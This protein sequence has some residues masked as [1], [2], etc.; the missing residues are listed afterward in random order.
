MLSLMQN[1]S[2]Y[3][4]YDKYNSKL[5]FWNNT[6]GHWPIN[7]QYLYYQTVYNPYKYNKKFIH[8]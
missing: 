1:N 4:L 5:L 3:A 2:T 6:I 7:K 8:I